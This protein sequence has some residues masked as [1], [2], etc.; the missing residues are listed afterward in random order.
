MS[1]TLIERLQFVNGQSPVAD[2]AAGGATSDVIDMAPF[3][4]IVFLVHRGDATGGT[5]A[6]TY[7]VLA[8]DDTVPSNTEAIKFNYRS[9]GGAVTAATAT[10]FQASAGDDKVDVIEVREDA[11][12]D[13]GYQYV[14]LNIAETVNDPQVGGVVVIG[15]LKD[16][17]AT[18]YNTVTD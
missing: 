8:C 12:A 11:L 2:H 17:E 18:A 1:G 15:E 3:Q 7:T 5:A 6:P 4:R 13:S 10:G 14:Q 16:A 9:N